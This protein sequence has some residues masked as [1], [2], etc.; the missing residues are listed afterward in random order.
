M[1][2]TPPARL[3]AVAKRLDVMHSAVKNVRSALDDLYA[4]LSDEQKA[5]FNRLGQSRSAERQG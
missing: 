5:Q 3:A 4:D 2:A 1:P